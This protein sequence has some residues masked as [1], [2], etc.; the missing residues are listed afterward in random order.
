MEMGRYRNGNLQ[1]NQNIIMAVS[2]FV[3][4]KNMFVTIRVYQSKQYQSCIK[5]E[6][7]VVDYRQLVVLQH[8][9]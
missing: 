3:I 2:K 6:R 7:R 5:I 4:F 9:L 8:Y 1:E